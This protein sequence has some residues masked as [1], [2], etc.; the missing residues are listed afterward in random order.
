MTCLPHILLEEV[1]Q[2][3]VFGRYLILS[4]RGM[5]GQTSRQAVSVPNDLATEG[6]FSPGCI[7]NGR[8]CPVPPI[9]V[10]LLSASLL[11]PRRNYPL[12]SV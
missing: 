3:A 9:Q 10:S 7:T 2:D 5:V 11:W 6:P 1:G 12:F 8:P 4:V